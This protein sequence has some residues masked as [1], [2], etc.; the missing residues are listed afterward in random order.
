MKCRVV[1]KLFYTCVFYY[2]CYFI[3]T[4]LHM[5]YQSDLRVWLREVRTH[6]RP[7]Y[8]KLQKWG[9][10]QEWVGHLILTKRRSEVHHNLQYVTPSPISQNPRERMC[11]AWI[12]FL[13]V[14]CPSYISRVLT[15]KSSTKEFKPHA[16]PHQVVIYCHCY[17]VD[18]VLFIM[19]HTTLIL[20]YHASC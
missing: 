7:I 18:F 16:L 15:L 17:N 2:V 6:L 1:I 9:V 20:Y 13:V 12:Y 19:S 10:G 3:L 5:V 14:T 8:L 4:Q 11:S